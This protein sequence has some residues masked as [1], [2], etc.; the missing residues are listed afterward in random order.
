[1]NADSKPKKNLKG[2]TKHSEK[3]N[4]GENE[5]MKSSLSKKGKNML[6]QNCD[7]TKSA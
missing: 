7:L 4:K 3:K 5:S 1:M 6:L 2:N